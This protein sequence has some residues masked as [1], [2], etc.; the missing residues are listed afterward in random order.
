MTVEDLTANDVL[1]MIMSH[2]HYGK[3]IRE[4]KEKLFDFPIGNR[5][6]NIYRIENGGKLY[7]YQ[8]KRIFK[9]YDLTLIYTYRTD[10]VSIWRTFD[11]Y[12]NWSLGLFR[13]KLWLSKYNENDDTWET[14]QVSRI[15]YRGSKILRV[16]R[17][18][19]CYDD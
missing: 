2:P 15:V 14:K 8:R 9:D 7:C 18:V 11:D 19:E 1:K 6:F 3:I 5:I 4:S 16:Y 12:E 13:A 10:L 17:G